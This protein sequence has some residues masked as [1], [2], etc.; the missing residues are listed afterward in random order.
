MNYKVFYPYILLVLLILSGSILEANT[1]NPSGESKPL[2]YQSSD[3]RDIVSAKEVWNA[4]PGKIR[5]LFSNLDLSHPGMKPVKKA[6]HSGDTLTACKKL[7][8][9]YKNAQTAEWLRS[10]TYQSGNSKGK[11]QVRQILNDKVTFGGV[12]CK[13]P[14]TKNGGWKWTYTGPEDDDEFAYSLNGHKYFS[15]FLKG[16]HETGNVEYVSKFDRVIR[17]WIIHNPLP[18]KPDSIYAVHRTSTEELDWRDIGEV[19][20]RDLEVG[21]R[22]GVG[23]PQT[24]YGFQQQE[25]FS[26]AGRLLML[27]HIPVQAEYLKQYHKKRHNWTTMEMDGLGL[28]G[29][30]FPEF[31]MADEW[32]NYALKVMQEEI[33]GQV[34]PDGTQTELSTKTQWVSLSRFESLVENFRNAGRSV[35]KSYLG[36]LEEMYGYMAYSM[37]PDGHQPLNNDSDRE[38]LRP[39]VLKAAREYDRPDWTYIAT[40]GKKGS[41]PEGLPSEVFPWAGIHIM[42]NGWDKMSHWSFFDT[43]PFGTGHQHSDKLHLSIHAFGRDL[44]VDGGRFTHQNYFSFDPAMWRGYFRSS[45]S[46]NLIL[47]DGKG[48]KSGPFTTDEP[49]DKGIEYLNKSAFDYARGTFSGGFNGVKGEVEHS[50]GVLYLRDNLWV[51]VDRIS[52]DRPRDIKALWH[53]NP[54]CNAKISK[55]NEVVSNDQGKGNLRIVPAGE[56]PWNVSIVSGK[57]EPYKQGW[58]S[59]TYGKKE[60]N[61]TAVYETS[62]NGDITFAWVLLPARGKVPEVKAKLMD[63][64]QGEVRITVKGKRPVV[65]EV[66]PIHGE[67]DIREP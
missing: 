4:Y 3:W 54:E 66:P 11:K 5:S 52:T 50:R 36:R 40:N 17:D 45:F 62:I 21:R 27:Y 49:M 15:L 9:Y 10:K 13:I 2:T 6:L 65:V 7:I 16:F 8:S 46:H 24:F 33:N 1:R 30:T 25:Q 39:R 58:Y 20:W 32:V 22:F 44:L 26:P 37:R 48:Q 28:V 55:S 34:Y 63:S 51:V 47:I 29:L 12:T 57:T 23:W 56:I 43:G 67:P 38:D 41:R 60:A 14:K 31:K 64:E 19:V 59:E 42:R 61:P 35:P 18:E 53:Y